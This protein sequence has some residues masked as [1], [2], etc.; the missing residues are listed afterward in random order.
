[1]IINKDKKVKYNRRNWKDYE[2]SVLKTIFYETNGYPDNETVSSLAVIFNTDFHKIKV[3][4]QNKR[5]RK[6]C[7]YTEE[8]INNYLKFLTN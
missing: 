7:I 5:Q 6:N 1:M 2:E 3:W 8:V 4:F